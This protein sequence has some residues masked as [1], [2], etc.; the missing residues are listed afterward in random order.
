LALLL[1]SALYPFKAWLPS[2]L[3]VSKYTIRETPS[4]FALMEPLGFGNQK[5]NLLNRF[6][7]SS[8]MSGEQLAEE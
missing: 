5:A 4:Q 6:F 3:D 7:H 1:T 2:I 8:A